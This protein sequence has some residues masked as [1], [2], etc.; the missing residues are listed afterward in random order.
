MSTLE[1]TKTETKHEITIFVNTEPK[2]VRGKEISYE[3]V[4]HLEYGDDVPTGESVNIL[5]GYRKGPG[6]KHDGSLV[7]GQSVKIKEGMAFSVRRADKS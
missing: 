1:S 3:E 4:L 7:A 2:K 5:V 6:E